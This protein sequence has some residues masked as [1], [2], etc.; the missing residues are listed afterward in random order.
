MTAAW[1][2]KPCSPGPPRGASPAG[3]GAARACVQGKDLLPE[4]FRSSVPQTEQVLEV[5]FEAHTDG[6]AREK[7]ACLRSVALSGT[8]WLEPGVCAEEQTQ[9]LEPEL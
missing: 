7:L 6:A 3:G 9:V 4:A 2:G 1:S 8:V 5:S